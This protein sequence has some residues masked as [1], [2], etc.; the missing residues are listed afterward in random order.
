MKKT[1]IR[2]IGLYLN[3]FAWISPRLG[4][5]LAF[6][7]FC[8][9]VRSRITPEQKSFFHS[10]EPFSMDYEGVMVRGYRWGRG[11]ENILF[12]HGWQSHSYRWKAYIDA[13]SKDQYTIYA[14]DAPGHGQSGGDFLTVP[15]Y[16]S[17]IRRAILQ[18]GSVHTVISHSIGSFSL[19]YTLFRFPLLPVKRVIALAPPG[20]ATDFV[21]AFKITL[22]L[23]R[24]V[25]RLVEEQ[26]VH[27]YD[28]KPDFFSA[29]KFASHL[30]MKGLIIH[31]EEDREAP[32][33]YASSIHQA[34]KR[35]RLITTK[36]FG[37]NLR[38]S[39]VVGHVVDFISADGETAH[40]AGTRHPAS[41][42]R[43]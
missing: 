2:L 18:L 39:L 8:R 41:H 29:V 35:S 34:W 28:V 42:E 25:V 12:L 24:K 20:E 30:N 37:H 11:P 9:P 22:G 16:S 19:L 40:P 36:G 23:S 7:V 31:D 4:G 10:A 27:K 14:L 43:I 6:A 33:A 5:K 3:I 32:Y 26:F 17:V 1:L 13:L 15:V 21:N 38:S